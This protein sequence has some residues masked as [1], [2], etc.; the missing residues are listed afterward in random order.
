[1]NNLRVLIGCVA[2]AL[3]LLCV[4]DRAAADQ[5]PVWKPL[6]DG[7]TLNGW[8]KNGEGDWTVEDGAYVGRSN[9]AQTLRAP[10]FGPDVSGLH[11]TFRF[12]VPQRRQR[13]LHPH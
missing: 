1:M 2:I 6:A 4:E 13:L 8:H 12:P 10:G 3:G 7:K 11:R 5:P 9:N